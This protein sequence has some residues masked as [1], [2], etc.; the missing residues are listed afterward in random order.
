MRSAQQFKYSQKQLRTIFLFG[1]LWLVIFGLYF[2][3]RSESY[4]GYGYLVIGISFLA[5][6]IYKKTV[7]YATLKNGILTKHDMLPKRINLDQ[8]TDV[9]YYA[10]KY[11]I[12]TKQSEM[13]LNTMVLDKASIEEL[14]KIISQI[15]I[16]K[17]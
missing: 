14:K 5:S 15:N 9:N 6:Y 1:I 12:M 10:G 7:H 3:F 13:T 16:S 2:F 11:K 8:I 17:S 4:F